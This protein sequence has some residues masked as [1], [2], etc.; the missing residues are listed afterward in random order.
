MAFK[1]IENRKISEIVRQQIEDMIQRGEIQPGEKL[2]SVV[3]LADQF[4]VSR[5]AVREAL[6]AMRAVGIVT[7]KQGEG[8]FVNKY[9]FSNVVHSV[10]RERIIAKTEML[11]LF[12]MRK[13][14]EVGAAELAAEKREE[15]HLQ[16]LEHALK[17]MKEA[18]PEESLGEAADVTFHLAL[19]EASKNSMM[20]DMMQQLSE[21]LRKTMF[22]SRRAWLFSRRD[23]LE[24]LYEEHERIYKAIKKQEP[25]EARVAMLCH[26]QNV[27]NTLVEERE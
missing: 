20:I 24:R 15:A 8:T 13:I 25:E 17:D 21:T 1:Q 9:D 14:I 19:A 3:K 18:E 27:E 12:E 4:N 22:E 11:E 26:L 16:A 10:S 5:S 2:D 6:S 23:T 7:I